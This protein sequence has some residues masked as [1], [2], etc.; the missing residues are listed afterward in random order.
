MLAPTRSGVTVQQ[1]RASQPSHPGSLGNNNKE[2]HM[3]KAIKRGFT[4]VE[5]AVVAGILSVVILAFTNYL[6]AN[7]TAVET[8][9]TG[10]IATLTGFIAN[11]LP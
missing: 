5:L 6:T 4:L 9:N 10:E 1:R 7:R 11:E 8:A 2:Q 3:L